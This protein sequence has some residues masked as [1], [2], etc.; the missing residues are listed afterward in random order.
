MKTNRKML[1][2]TVSAL[3]LLCGATA[4][5]AA[6][7]SCDD[8]LTSELGERF[9][10]AMFDDLAPGAYNVSFQY[11]AEKSAGNADKTLKFG[12]LFDSQEGSFTRD[13]VSDSTALTGWNTYSFLTEAGGDS[14]FVFAHRGVPGSNYG[15][16]LQN[17][18]VTAVPEPATYAMFLAGLGAVLFMSRR[19][20]L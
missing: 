10:F 4:A 8:P 13:V 11:Q 3:A 17:I 16:S 1:A 19:R 2:S 14:G 12:F 9:C 15:M 7:H 6:S 20:R 18:Q 5:G